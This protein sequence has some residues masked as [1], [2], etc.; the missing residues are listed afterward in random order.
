MKRPITVPRKKKTGVTKGRNKPREYPK[1]KPKS[2]I[3][4]AGGFNPTAKRAIPLAKK[5]LRSPREARRKAAQEYL[6]MHD[7]PSRG[8]NISR[9]GGTFKGIF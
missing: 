4:G 7:K 1:G 5:D 3:T 8:R 9:R 2:Y 6:A